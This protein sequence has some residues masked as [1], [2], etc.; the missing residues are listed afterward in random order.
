MSRFKKPYTILVVD[1]EIGVR[2]AIRMILQGKYNVLT[3]DD[4]HEAMDIISSVEVDIVMLDIKMPKIDGLKLLKAMKAAAQDIEIALITAHPS[5]Q[6]AIEALR[7]GAY[8][9]VIKPFDKEKIEKVVHKGII[10]RTQRK[11]EKDMAANLMVEII[12][13]ASFQTK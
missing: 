12:N 1:D 9:Y 7:Y 2:E 8:D 5:T 11:L 6:S 13:K 4:P 10:R 3:S